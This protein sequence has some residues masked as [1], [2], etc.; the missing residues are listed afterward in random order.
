MHSVLYIATHCGIIGYLIVNDTAEMIQD[1]AVEFPLL[2]KS[3]QTNRLSSHILY[4]VWGN[5]TDLSKSLNS[6][7]VQ[8]ILLVPQNLSQ[9][10][11]CMDVCMYECVCMN[12]H[13]YIYIMCIYVHMY[14]YVTEQR[15]KDIYIF[16]S[17]LC[18]SLL[19]L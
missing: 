5:F 18:N 3:L 7:Q 13:V 6:G 1:K 4:G 19:L 2:Q 16:N 17:T 9:L 14:M 12:V 15:W 10:Y 11:V 8:L